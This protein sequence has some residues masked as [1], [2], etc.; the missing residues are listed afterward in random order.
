MNR[1]KEHNDCF[2]MQMLNDVKNNK[3]EPPAMDDLDDLVSVWTQY[4]TILN[5]IVISVQFS[6]YDTFVLIE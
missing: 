1:L 3:G 6:L 4:Y 5:H 2:K